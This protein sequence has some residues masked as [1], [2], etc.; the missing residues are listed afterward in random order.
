MQRA[1]GKSVNMSLVC[2]DIEVFGNLRAE[3][4]CTS[5]TAHNLIRTEPETFP[6][7]TYTNLSHLYLSTLLWQLEARLSQVLEHPFRIVRLGRRLEVLDSLGAITS[8]GI[9]ATVRIIQI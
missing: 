6:S 4:I 3:E 2:L 8:D 5:R 1:K 9:L 7:Y